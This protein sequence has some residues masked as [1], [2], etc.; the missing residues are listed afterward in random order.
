MLT[1]LKVTAKGLFQR[2]QRVETNVGERV[3]WP[4]GKKRGVARAH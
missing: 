4:R 1:A 3:G 2:Q